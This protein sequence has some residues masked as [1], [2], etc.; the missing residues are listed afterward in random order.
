MLTLAKL[1]PELCQ[2]SSERLDRVSEDLLIG[3]DEGAAEGD[4]LGHEEPVE[5]IGMQH[6]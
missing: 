4:R 5:W 1:V 6:G 2:L 3:R